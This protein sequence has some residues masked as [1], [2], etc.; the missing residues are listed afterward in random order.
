MMTFIT[1]AIL[2]H[3]GLL[4][5]IWYYLDG[6]L[7]IGV[8]VLAQILIGLPISRLAYAM[9]TK[10]REVLGFSDSTSLGPEWVKAETQTTRGELKHIF[11][12]LHLDLGKKNQQTV[13]DLN[14]LAW[15]SIVVWSMISIILINLIGQNLLIYISPSVLLALVTAIL[16]RN[17]YQSTPRF[18]YD[19]ILDHLEFH[20]FTRLDAFSVLLD[21]AKV[22]FIVEW[23]KKGNRK[24][25]GDILSYCLIETNVRRIEIFYNVGLP[26]NSF[27]VVK[28]KSSTPL[29]VTT[30]EG[31]SGWTVSTDEFSLTLTNESGSLDLTDMSSI[32]A[33]PSHIQNESDTIREL[34]ESLLP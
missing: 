12:K 16:Y 24:T 8:F 3:A 9:G 23:W 7:E 25:I 30:F 29:N 14:D 1:P 19:D 11:E 15:F 33:T 2:G 28:V 4:L 26:S 32:I 5:T 13:D 20:I 27:E 31:L 6:F 18:Q 10:A 34:L 21:S 22:D 17:G